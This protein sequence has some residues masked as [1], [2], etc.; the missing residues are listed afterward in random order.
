[1]GLSDISIFPLSGGEPS[2]HQPYLCCCLPVPPLAQTEAE[3]PLLG[4][5]SIQPP[6]PAVVVSKTIGLVYV[7]PS[8]PMGFFKSSMQSLYSPCFWHVPRLTQLIRLRFTCWGSYSI[9][10]GLTHSGLWHK[11][12]ACMPGW[13]MSSSDQCRS[14]IRAIRCTYSV[15]QAWSGGTRQHMTP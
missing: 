11:W 1:V 4:D 10:R 15:F 13:S 9:C 12:L 8:P 14:N 5:V 7:P 2:L 3:S 6:T